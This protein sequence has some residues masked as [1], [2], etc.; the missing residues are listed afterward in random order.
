M[1]NRTS[2]IDIH[3]RVATL[4]GNV[5]MIMSDMYNGGKD[6]LKTR[7]ITLETTLTTRDE[8]SAKNLKLRDDE[9]ENR[10]KRRDF[11]I[12]TAIAILGLL[13]AILAFLEGS[14]QVKA[15]ELHWPKITTSI[16]DQYAHNKQQLEISTY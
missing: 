4:E 6:G 13:V 7:F 1:I 14:R 11:K 12:T 16:S 15:G 3:E 10:Q 8:E 2:G 5:E 9:R